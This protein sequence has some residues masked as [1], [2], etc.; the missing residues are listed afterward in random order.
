MPESRDRRQHIETQFRASGIEHYEF[1]DAVGP[2]DAEVKELYASGRVAKYPPCFRCGELS[3]GSDDCNNVLVPQQVATCVSFLKLWRHI[4]ETGIKTALVV[5]DDV[6]FAK[7]A[8]KVARVVLDRG[9]LEQVGLKEDVPTLLRLGW[10]AGREHQLAGRIALTRDGVRMANHCFAVNRAMC[11][12]LLDEFDRVETTAD[13]FTHR[14]VGSTVRNFTLQPPIASDLSFSFGAVASLIHPKKKRIAYLQKF[15]PER[16]DEIEAAIEAVRKHVK[17]ILY[18]PL[19]A[20]GHPRCGSRYISALL[21]ACGLDVGHERMGQHGIS[22]WMFAVEDDENPWARDPLSVSRKHKHFGHVIHFVRDPRMAIPSIVRENRH[23]EKSYAFRR[24]H[25]QS[26]LHVDLDAAS[27][28]VERALLS[29]LYWNQLVEAQEI[30]LTLRVEDA[31]D[32]A[33]EFLKERQIVPPDRSMAA[34]PPKNVNTDK[35]YQGKLPE[36][37]SLSR[38]D[39]ETVPDDLKSRINQSCARY[40]YES[41]YQ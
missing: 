26:A 11:R 8:P 34:P 10:T 9:F 2:D 4:L 29:Y 30:D 35:L 31:E 38:S 15:H 14:V 24:K 6:I 1:F 39:W 18:R 19:L 20:I 36:R 32:I 22:S 27:S 21:K 40:G 5:E 41:L 25:I 37:P 13:E 23:S 28:E 33:L 7:Y 16:R 17:H 3:C 12:K